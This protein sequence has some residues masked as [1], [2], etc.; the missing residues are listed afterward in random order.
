MPDFQ[1]IAPASRK[2]TRTVRVG[3]VDLLGNTRNVTLT[4][5]GDGVTDGQVNT[6]RSA[7]GDATNGGVYFDEKSVIQKQDPRDSRAFAEPFSKVS[8]LGVLVFDHPNPQVDEVYLEI[9]CIDM[10]KVTAAGDLNIN[11]GEIQAIIN[12]ALPILNDSNPFTGDFYFSHAYYSD[13]K[14]NSKVNTGQIPNTV[15]P[16]GTPDPQP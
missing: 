11:D 3:I 12:A 16:R 7:I 8:D 1:A 13:R 6:L 10:G 15:D 9:P 2:T 14:G 4:N 5:L